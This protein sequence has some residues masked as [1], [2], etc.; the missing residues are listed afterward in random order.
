MV[1]SRF[2]EEKTAVKIEFI[3]F[4]CE[5][6]LIFTAHW[7]HPVRYE[8]STHKF[9]WFLHMM[10]KKTDAEHVYGKLFGWVWVYVDAHSFL[11]ELR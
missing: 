1:Q 8:H 5:R 7:Y 3:Q 4:M 10:T 6:H 2:D 9:L 11:S